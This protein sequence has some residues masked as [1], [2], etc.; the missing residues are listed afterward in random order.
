MISCLGFSLGQFIVLTVPTSSNLI[1]FD[2]PVLV[3]G[4]NRPDKILS[5]LHR[6]SELGVTNLFFSLDLR[7]NT[8]AGRDFP[9]PV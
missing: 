9:R 7:R 2:T 8:E 5:L 4:F 6:L 1:S 3:I